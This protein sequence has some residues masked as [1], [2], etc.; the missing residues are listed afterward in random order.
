MDI[1]RL[2][3]GCM[4]E[5][6]RPGVCPHCGYDPANAKAQGH[7]LR[8][9]TILNGKY[10]VG[11]VLGEGGFGIT[12]IGYDLNLEMPV[13][14]KEFYPNGF[15]T[16]ESAVTSTVSMYRGANLETV[17]KWKNNFI[18]EA[19]TLAKCS[20]LSG[21]VGVKDFFEENGTAY[22]VME[23]LDG[24]TLK[25]YAKA[26][27]GRLEAE[28]LLRTLEPVMLS[29]AQVHGYGLIHRDI[30]PD[31]IMLLPGGQMKLLDFGAA[32]DY[33]SEGEKSLSVMLKPGYAPE[34]QYRTKGKQGPWS[35]VY[36][37]AATIYKCITGV[38][39]PESMERLR[40]DELKRPGELGIRLRPQVEQALMKGMAVYAEQR[41]Q[42]MQEFMAALYQGGQASDVPLPEPG[43][44]QTTT[45]YMERRADTTVTP[46]QVQPADAV[47]E[48]VKKNGKLLGAAAGILVVVIVVVLAVGGKSEKRAESV[49]TTPDTAYT[50]AEAP[51]T[52]DAEAAEAETDTAQEED[53]GEADLA[54][55]REC[56]DAG[57]YAGALQHF[58]AAL[59][60]GAVDNEEIYHLSSEAYLKMGDVVNAVQVLNMGIE[61]TGSALLETRKDYVLGHVQTLRIEEYRDAVMTM[62]EEYDTDGRCLR[63]EYYDNQG[64]LKE[65]G[66]FWYDGVQ[67][68][69]ETHYYGNG[70][71]KWSR[72][73]DSLGRESEYYVYN[74]NGSLQ[75]HYETQYM[76][77]TQGRQNYY[78]SNGALQWWKECEYDGNGHLIR[79]V[80]YNSDG[81]MNSWQEYQYDEEGRAVYTA[82][83]YADGRKSGSAS[84][85]YDE[86]GSQTKSANYD[87]DDN[88]SWGEDFGYQYDPLGNVSEKQQYREGT[89]EV[90]DTWN[91]VY[92]YVYTE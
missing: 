56:L 26:N 19:R 81:S 40:E 52:K 83:H 12:Y 51:D 74:E 34:E 2:C 84:Y 14:V 23:Y 24:M 8:P 68:T 53:K 64:N 3:M 22:I 59:Q 58:N 72:V 42:N 1:E 33:A 76:S 78:G 66:E 65:W 28:E 80:S 60:K 55:G 36:A 75:E 32:R 20:H 9:Y 15:V 48:F 62:L 50:E 91:Y 10:L 67:L 13:A 70:A 7:Y 92:T 29:L 17:Q 16:R 39:P 45:G 21:I 47:S 18:R 82:G 4:K 27:G 69:A 86:N 57:D 54:S 25:A 63:Q 61:Q 41:Y 73:Y 79:D 46:G 87:A 31:N 88:Y 77:E 89:E 44:E 90:I 6:E 11:R 71:T 37:F 30:S 35:D 43:K 38:T 85:Q 49:E 5:L